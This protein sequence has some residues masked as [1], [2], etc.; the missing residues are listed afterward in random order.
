MTPVRIAS[1]AAVVG[2]GAMGGVFFAFSTF[3]MQ[4]L[5]RLPA[6]DGIAAM[7][8]INE[9]A[10]RP[11]FVTGLFGTAVLCLGLGVHVLRHRDHTGGRMLLAGSSLYLLG[12][13]GLTIAYHVP[14]NDALAT[15]DPNAHASAA[16]WQSYLGHWT[17]W[18]HVRTISSLAAA[19]LIALALAQHAEKDA[20]AA[21][22]PVTSA[23]P[24]APG[25][26]NAGAVR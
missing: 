6:P 26:T 13:I 2:T 10:V 16:P 1:L 17:A 11:A 12:T 18:N 7:R 3:V 22:S 15:L 19:L 4:G 5:G 14:A 21:V 24:W 25:P 20:Q 23:E 9:T 8:H